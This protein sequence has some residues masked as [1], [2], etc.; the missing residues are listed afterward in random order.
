MQRISFLNVAYKI[1]A[2]LLA[3]INVVFFCWG[4]GTNNNTFQVLRYLAVTLQLDWVSFAAFVSN[5]LS[6]L[7][8]ST[9]AYSDE[10]KLRSI[11]VKAAQ[12]FILKGRIKNIIPYISP[13]CNTRRPQKIEV[14]KPS[15]TMFLRVEETEDCASKALGPDVISTIML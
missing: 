7:Q 15:R 3:P 13:S 5:K 6:Q 11:V 8:L 10:Q 4:G 14:V 12:R 1:L 2:V 9:E